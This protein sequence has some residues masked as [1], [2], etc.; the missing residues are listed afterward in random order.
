MPHRSFA[1]AKA[2]MRYAMHRGEG[3][4]MIT[5]AP[6]TGKTT[7]IDALVAEVKAESYR[8]ARLLSAQVE[9][10][11]VLRLV[12]SAFGLPLEQADKSTILQRL[13]ERFG[14]DFRQ[15]RRSLLIID[16]A[17]GLGLSALEELRLLTNAREGGQPLLQIFLVGQEEL[18]EMVTSPQLEQLNQRMIAAYHMD[19][20]KPEEFVAYILHRLRKAGWQGRPA[21]E[22]DLFA[23]IFRVSNGVPRRINHICSRLLLHGFLE[24]K[25]RLDSADVEVVVKELRAEHYALDERSTL[26]AQERFN[27]EDLHSIA[28]SAMT[29]RETQAPQPVAVADPSVTSASTPPDEARQSDDSPAQLSAEVVPQTQQAA[30]ATAPE[31]AEP[32][33]PLL[34]RRVPSSAEAEPERPTAE[35]V[36]EANS[37]HGALIPAL[38]ASLLITALLLAVSVAPMQHL[39][40]VASQAVWQTLG[41]IQVRDRI[42]HWSGGRLP[43][44]HAG[45]SGKQPVILEKIERA[46]SSEQK[47]VASRL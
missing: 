30:A 9:A 20:L 3:F 4:V 37:G 46:H 23:P 38:V 26:L 18:R 17:Q 41:V 42:M 13:T 34:T 2:Y 14:S 43:L 25:S 31:E 16:E 28:Q 21:L 33:V 19:P 44:S 22:P 11:D 8:L 6:G 12:A 36:S 27:A 24:E 40:R 32:M 35:P 10:D 47:R 29:V 5:G 1:K 15:G 45:R 39:E 7:L